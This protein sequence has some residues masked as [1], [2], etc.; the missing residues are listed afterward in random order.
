MNNHELEPIKTNHTNASLSGKNF[1]D[2]ADLPI[3]RIGNSGLEQEKWDGVLSVWM[4]PFWAR[5]K[6]LFDGRVNLVCIGKTQP[7]IA[8]TVG[9]YFGH[10]KK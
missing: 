10:T 8:V 6:F 2:V 3:T 4:V 5:L 1:D 9:D 7:P